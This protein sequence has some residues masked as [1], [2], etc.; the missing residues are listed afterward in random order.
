[1][2]QSMS[3]KNVRKYSKLLNLDIVRILVR[4]GTDH[5]KDLHL[6]DG[7]IIYLYPGGGMYKERE[8]GELVNL[9]CKSMRVM[10]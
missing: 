3:Q 2:R 7:T 5:R 4:G 8:N 1:M 6:K 9:G 10:R